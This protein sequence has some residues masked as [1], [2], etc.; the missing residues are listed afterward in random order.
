[1]SALGLDHGMAVGTDGEARPD[2]DQ[3]GIGHGSVDV[4]LREPCIDE[5][6]DA[7][8]VEGREVGR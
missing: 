5:Y 1:M 2:T 4:S 6:I 3:G 7:E 8:W